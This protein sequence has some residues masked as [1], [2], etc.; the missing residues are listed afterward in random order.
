MVSNPE[1]SVYLIKVQKLILFIIFQKEHSNLKVSPRETF[2][3]FTNERTV[4]LTTK[5]KRKRGGGF[6][7]CPTSYEGTLTYEGFI[8]SDNI[9]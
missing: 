8:L 9:K 3:P 2:Q 7:Y 6:R 5:K 1:F 4:L